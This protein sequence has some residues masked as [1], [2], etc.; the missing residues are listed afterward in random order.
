MS[1]CPP[2]PCA[3]SP[4][5]LLGCS[6]DCIASQWSVSVK[7]GEL[8]CSKTFFGFSLFQSF[9]GCGGTFCGILRL[10]EG[11]ADILIDVEIGLLDACT[12]TGLGNDIGDTKGPGGA[13][14]L[15]TTGYFWDC[16]SGEAVFGRMKQEQATGKRNIS[17]SKPLYLSQTSNLWKFHLKNMPE[18]FTDLDTDYLSTQL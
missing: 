6:E 13:M 5:C 7:D 3:E 4:R 15:S 9:A 8:C 17:I 2:F 12:G 1:I 14:L 18:Y 10:V 11:R 16:M